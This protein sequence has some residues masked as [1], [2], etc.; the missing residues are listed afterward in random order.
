MF[1]D[2]HILRCKLRR[3]RRKFILCLLQ[4]LSVA[5]QREIL[6]RGREGGKRIEDEKYNESGGIAAGRKKYDVEQRVSE[7]IVIR[8]SLHTTEA[9]VVIPFSVQFRSEAR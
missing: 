8:Y 5:E 2:K 4:K 3:Q 7:Q 1:C 9:F 6:A